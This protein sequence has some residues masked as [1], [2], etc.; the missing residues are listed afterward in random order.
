MYKEYSSNKATYESDY[1]LGSMRNHAGM[2]R[3]KNQMSVRKMDE[4]EDVLMYN[5]QGD[6]KVETVIHGDSEGRGESPRMKFGGIGVTK[7][8]DVSTS[9]VKAGN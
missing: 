1:K 7:T 8:V 3:S 2:D 6:P 4:D 9:V 5:A